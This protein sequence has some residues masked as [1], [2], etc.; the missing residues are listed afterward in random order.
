[1]QFLNWFRR[2]KYLRL[3]TSSRQLPP[4]L[5]PRPLH[6]GVSLFP[7]RRSI[8]SEEDTHEEDVDVIVPYQRPALTH[9]S[10]VEEKAKPDNSISRSEYAS[11]VIRQP[12]PVRSVVSMPNRRSR[13]PTSRRGP[14]SVTEASA[15]GD[16]LWDAIRKVGQPRPARRSRNIWLW[17]IYWFIYC[18][19]GYNDYCIFV[20]LR[21]TVV[22]P[23]NPVCNDKVRRG[24]N[25]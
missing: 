17:L 19:Y 21:I 4:I 10:L 7:R 22:L 1:M 13:S 5:R 18:R 11:S 8:T 23:S 2:A 12:S 9:T 3:P 16:R 20:L 24:R 15:G 14:P 6:S 25:E